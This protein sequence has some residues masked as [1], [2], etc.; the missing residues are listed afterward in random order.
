MYEILWS[1]QSSSALIHSTH[2]H[3]FLMDIEKDDIKIC[4]VLKELWIRLQGHGHRG[5]TGQIVSLS[6]H[7]NKSGMGKRRKA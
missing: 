3:S 4:C 1:N 7:Q 2:K 6:G 5:W